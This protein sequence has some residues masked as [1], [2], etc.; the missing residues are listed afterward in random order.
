MWNGCLL[1]IDGGQAAGGVLY[2]AGL[3]GPVSFQHPPAA[4]VAVLLAVGDLSE[5]GQ[6]A[7]GAV[8]VGKTAAARDK[9][10]EAGLVVSV[11][12]GIALTAVVRRGRSD[13]LP[14]QAV[15][16]VEIG[17]LRGELPTTSD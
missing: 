17:G 8:A 2:V 5:F 16:V 11:S 9:T 12:S 1:T 14:R 15:V 13:V 3:P 4:V 6:G 7:V 10:G